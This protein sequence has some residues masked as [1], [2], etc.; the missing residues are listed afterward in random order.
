MEIITKELPDTHQIY[1][2]SDFHEGSGN[3][4]ETALLKAINRVKRSRNSYVAILG[5]FCEAR[6]IDHPFYLAD[7]ERKIV[8]PLEQYTQIAKK[9]LP[10]KSRILVAMEGNHDRGLSRFGMFVKDLVCKELSCIFGTYTCIL[11]VRMKKGHYKMFLTH[12]RKNLYSASPD[13]SQRRA[14]LERQ[15]RDRLKE[16]MDDCL[17]MARGHTHRLLVAPPT[18]SLFLYTDTKKPAGKRIES[19]YKVL[20]GGGE[21]TYID[22]HLRWYVST[23]GFLRNYKEGETSYGEILDLDPLEIG[24]AV[25]KVKEGQVV[26]VEEVRLA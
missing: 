14:N 9:L 17:I 12:G 6:A 25:V 3:Q 10:L 1:L 16:K 5:D 2:M 26:A 24:M 13:P 11:N 20:I 8:L 19:G 18:T 4:D 21:Y 15:L 23:G 7:K 22:E